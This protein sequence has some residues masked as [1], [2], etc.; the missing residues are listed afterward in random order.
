MP[1]TLILKFMKQWFH[2]VWFSTQLSFIMNAVNQGGK[3]KDGVGW[4]VILNQGKSP[5]FM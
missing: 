3:G 2:S 1:E 5:S 4:E